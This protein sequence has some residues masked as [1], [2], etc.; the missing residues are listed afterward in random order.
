ML[1]K[2]AGKSGLNCTEEELE[3]TLSASLSGLELAFPAYLVEMLKERSQLTQ[4]RIAEEN[5][6]PSS[7]ALPA[8]LPGTVPTLVA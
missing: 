2:A 6:K 3:L 1:G 4:N 7:V 5:Q 8:E